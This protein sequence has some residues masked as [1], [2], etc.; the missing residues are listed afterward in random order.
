MMIHQADKKIK[1]FAFL[2]EFITKSG[3]FSFDWENSEKFPK[4]EFEQPSPNYAK[5]V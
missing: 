4:K 5:Q 2:Q 3:F 1:G